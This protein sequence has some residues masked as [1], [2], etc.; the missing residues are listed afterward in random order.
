MTNEITIKEN[1]KEFY[2]ELLKVAI[3][4]I[5]QQLILVTLN[6]ADTLMVG[7]LSEY[8]LA[9]VGAANQVY[10]VVIDCIFGFLSGAAVFA[11]QYWGIKDLKTLRKVLG[12]AYVMVTFFAVPMVILAYGLAPKL[13]GIFA[14]DPYVI[15]MGVEYIRIAC[16]TYLIA[17]ITFTISYNS[18]AVMM[19]KWPTIFNAI[20]VGINI[21]LNYCLIYGN[22]GLPR[23]E[24]RGAA[25]ATLIA[26]SIECILMI[27]YVYI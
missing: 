27:A 17:G 18:R 25:I 24:V 3:P 19:L 9:A 14:T 2:S 23:L 5:L 11:V 4:V 10:F 13:I 22:C 26:R 1:K 7:N 15:E 20:A 21:F 16:F 8:A 12:I 6:L